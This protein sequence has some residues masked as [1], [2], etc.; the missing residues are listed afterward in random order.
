MKNTWKRTA[1]FV[2]AMALVVGA[3]PT[4]VGTG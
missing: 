2:L 3:V 4:N 1:A